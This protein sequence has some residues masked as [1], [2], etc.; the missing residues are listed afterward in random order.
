MYTS[1]MYTYT[2][3]R[4]YIYMYTYLAAVY[5]SRLRTFWFDKTDIPHLFENWE[6][7]VAEL[8]RCLF[9]GYEPRPYETLVRELYL[10]KRPSKLQ[11]VTIINIMLRSV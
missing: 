10:P 11:A 6:Q 2:H 4:V 5:H 3:M 1:Y 8:H 9:A 7:H